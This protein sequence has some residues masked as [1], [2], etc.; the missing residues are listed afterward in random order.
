[1]E[2]RYSEAGIPLGSL[3]ASQL[4]VGA[5]PWKASLGKIGVAPCQ[6]PG[7]AHL[8]VEGP[9]AWGPVAWPSWFAGS[10]PCWKAEWGVEGSLEEAVDADADAEVAVVAGYCPYD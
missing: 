9:A 1:M 2:M 7:A 4:P 8:E 5:G 10:D 6:T 3:G